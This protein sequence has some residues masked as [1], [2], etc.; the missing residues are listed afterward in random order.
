MRVLTKKITAP[1][2][3]MIKVTEADLE[4]LIKSLHFTF[5]LG[6][7]IGTRMCPRVKRLFLAVTQF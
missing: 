5:L 6:I 3:I 7:K 1:Y 4:T 2:V